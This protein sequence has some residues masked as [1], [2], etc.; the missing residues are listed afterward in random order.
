MTTLND[1]LRKIEATEANLAKLEKIWKQLSSLLPIAPIF[2]YD[3]EQV[4]RY[5]L[6]SRHFERIRAAMPKID[7][8]EIQN[9][10]IPFH[11]VFQNTLNIHQYGEIGD[12]INFEKEARE[13]GGHLSEYRF[14]LIQKRQEL[15]RLVIFDIAKSIEEDI[16]VLKNTEPDERNKINHSAWDA[17]QK[18][19]SS[20]EII[21]GNAA[22]KPARWHD[23][24]RHISYREV[25]DLR[26]IESLDWPSVKAGLEQA[27]RK[28]YD[29]IPVEVEDL[30][31]LVAR[32]PTGNVVVELKWKELSPTDFERLIYNIVV[33]TDGYENTQWLTHTNAPDRGRDL[34]AF[35]VHK[36]LLSGVQ[37]QRIII[38]CK[39]YTSK[40]VS[41]EDVSLLRIQVELWEPPKVDVLVIATSSRFTTD[42]IQLIENQNQKQGLRI[43]MW[44]DTTLEHL[45]SERPALIGE[46]KLR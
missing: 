41:T 5:D 21:I 1:T 22:K 7:G 15:A 2:Q 28:E 33:N 4:E 38:A 14:R 16:K 35:R 36:D 6:L 45:L 32:K 24:M 43:E 9:S 3:Q 44:S 26:D 17:M 40:S 10:I 19:M 18:K 27:L 39:H 13:Q 12:S 30:S 25:S 42:A 11:D 29:P 46:F 34:S 8:H 20:I 23:M 37:R 31:V